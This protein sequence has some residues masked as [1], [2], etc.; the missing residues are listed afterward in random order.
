MPGS[1]NGILTLAG[2]GRASLEEKRSRFLA[3][4]APAASFDEALALA[5]SARAQYHDARHH[6]WACRLA[7]GDERASDD[8]EPQG[9]AGAPALEALRAAGVVNA[10]VVVTRWFGGVLLGPGGLRRAYGSAAKLA[11]AQAPTL[12]L[13]R[14]AVFSVGCEYRFYEP[15][16]RLLASLGG[17]A[18]EADFGDGV[19][20]LAVLP[21]GAA[22]EFLRAARERTTGSAAVGET[23]AELRALG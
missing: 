14:C 2:E 20:F 3:L 9:T 22:Q 1:S 10:A 17:R 7:G 12:L 13:T 6:I 19:R 8:G 4:A 21:E 18:E 16:C 11:L 5:A 23:E 15:L